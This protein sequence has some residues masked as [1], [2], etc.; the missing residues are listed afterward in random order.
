VVSTV[1]T[2]TFVDSG[3]ESGASYTYRVTPLNNQLVGESVTVDVTTKAVEKQGIVPAPEPTPIA[4]PKLAVN[5]DLA[6]AGDMR[7][8]T[9]RIAG[10]FVKARSKVTVSLEAITGDRAGARAEV[11]LSVR[12]NKFGKFNAQLDLADDLP[13]GRYKLILRASDLDGNLVTR[14]VRFTIDEKQA[15]APTTDGGEGT[16]AAAGSG[17]DTK[18]DSVT[19]GEAGNGDEPT[20]TTLPSSQE[21]PDDTDN[22]NERPTEV[23][24]VI[25]RTTEGASLVVTF[26]VTIGGMFF[27]FVAGWLLRGRRMRVRSSRR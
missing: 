21:S 5:V 15:G 12:A 20:P 8:S 1:G 18:D 3:L 10:S 6:T 14:T 24:T 7:A 23:V 9:A 22:V 25:K 2:T 13:S 17:S 26:L 16:D 27:G 4:Q 19:D 11:V